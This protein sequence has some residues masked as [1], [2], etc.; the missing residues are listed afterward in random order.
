M[1]TVRFSQQL[2]DDIISKASDMF[3]EGIKNA[4]ENVPK[5][6]GKKIYDSLFSPETQAKM[7]ALPDWYFNKVDVIRLEGFVNAPSEQWSS[8]TTNIE[9]WK[10]K[11]RALSLKL[12][13]K[14]P[15][16]PHDAGGFSSNPENNKSGLA[17]RFGN[18]GS[19]VFDNP[20]FEWLKEPFKAYTKGI[21]DIHK[22]RN[23]FIENVNKVMNAYSTLAP[24][25][26]AWKPLWELLPE[27]AKERH[28]KIVERPKTKT[29]EE[30][31]LDLNSMTST[32]AFNKL[33]RK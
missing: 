31:G 13:M 3:A 9:M 5:D 15:F 14:L 21:F 11:G 30:L 8:D 25:L 27:D 24:A 20:K 4:Q 12:N 7:N 17:V 28:K 32:I 16:P 10:V 26:K 6:W 29:G 19:V 23:D 22:K 2:K 33:T 18:E 1:A